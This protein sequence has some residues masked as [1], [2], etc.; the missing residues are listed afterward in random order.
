QLSR[1]H[2]APLSSRSRHR[3][4]RSCRPWPEARRRGLLAPQRQAER[5][6]SLRLCLLSTIEPAE[7][8]RPA[9]SMDR[10]LFGGGRAATALLLERCI[11]QI[12]PKLAE[13]PSGEPPQSSD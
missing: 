1:T 4:T 10:F 11:G 13:T 9:G 7:V 2:A 8:L 3:R 12:R 6:V 5:L